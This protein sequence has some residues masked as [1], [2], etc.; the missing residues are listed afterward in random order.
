MQNSFTPSINIVRDFDRLL[1][2]L[3]T[4]NSH[5]I[6]DQIA[7]D[8]Q[9]G[10]RSFNLIGSYGTGKSAFLWAFEKQLNQD[11]TYFGELNGHFNG[12]KK[13]DFVN[14]VGEY[15]SLVRSLA[16]HYGIPRKYATPK[17]V[18]SRLLAHSARLAG[19]KKGLVVA[20]DELGKFLEFAAK[21]NPER[22]LY[23]IQQLSEFCNDSSKNVIL[24]TSLH[25]AFDSYAKVLDQSQRLEWEKVSGRLRELTF[26]EPVEHLLFLAAEY[27]GTQVNIRQRNYPQAAI[28]SYTEHSGAVRFRDYLAGDLARDLNPIEPLA[29][30]ALALALQ[31]YGQNERSLFTFLSSND[32]LGI[33]GYD[34]SANPLFNLSCV[35]DYL[36]SNH[37]SFI[38]T[39]DNPNYVQW[40][41]IQRAIERVEGS[42][43]TDMSGA[44]RLVKS[45]GL[46]NIL[47]VESTKIDD[48]FIVEYGSTALGIADPTAIAKE[49]ESK[50]TLRF[51]Q[52]KS[53]YILFDGT[54]FDFGAAF[55]AASTKVGKL[56]DIVQP[57][58]D[59]FT[60]PAILCKAAHLKFGTPRFFAYQITSEPVATVPTGEVDGIIN[61]LFPIGHTMDQLRAESKKS[62]EAIL[63]CVFREVDTIGE[64]LWEIDKTRFIWSSIGDDLVAK[65]EVAGILGH[66]IGELNRLVMDSMFTERVVWLFRGRE[67]SIHSKSELNKQLSLITQRVY[68]EVPVFHNELIN[69]HRL[70]PG[71]VTAR[72]N[73]IERLLSDWDKDDLAFPKDKFPAE[74]TIY[75]ALLK[76]TGIHKKQQ[77]GWSLRKPSEPS[78]E[79]LW[80]RCEAFLT[81]AKSTQRSV[82]DLFDILLAKPLKL[83]QGL[84]DVWIPI[85]LFI[86][87]EDYA[88]FGEQGY[89][90]TLTSDVIDLI[91]KNPDRFFVKTFDIEGIRLDLLNRYRSFLN[92]EPTQRVSSSSFVDT[93]RPFLSFYRGLPDYAKTTKRLSSHSLALRNVIATAKDPEKT[94]FEEFPAA[95]GYTLDD[96]RTSDKKL[97]RYVEDLQ[98]GI[99]EIRTAF[100]GLIDR[101]EDNL[102]QHLGYSGIRF[103]AY[104]RHLQ[105]RF[106]TLQRHLMLNN[107][108]VLYQRLT[109]E[110]DDRQ[111]W[112]SSVS[113]AVLGKPL[114]LLK[115]EEEAML[116]AKLLGTIAELD[117]LCEITKLEVDSE[118]EEVVRMEITTLSSGTEKHTLRIPKRKTTEAEALSETLRSRLSKDKATN[119]ITLL[120]LLREQN[121]HE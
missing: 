95:L 47:G 114:E 9:S 105:A 25:Q 11:A 54:D 15:D 4:R 120:K 107:Q 58:K 89:I 116:H 118:K 84:A 57:L 34:R 113:H 61:L 67:V 43:E 72:K 63:Y 23:F 80:K 5:H 98:N 94:F 35:Y 29:A 37:Y 38:G 102:L 33:R 41:A 106:A 6:Y 76:N 32:H 16:L 69:R 2:Y 53:R 66:Q 56:T 10:I 108:K 109:S 22:E 81:S 19:K 17:S 26:N 24:I 74:K 101:I 110:I 31:R 85:F 40:A 50:K 13:F 62:G 46:L 83:K 20:I 59:H 78:F 119:I 49:L 30:A 7:A 60:L 104:R 77:T 8:F 82:A 86:R 91:L 88:L 36:V 39:R 117:T 14:I 55:A 42:V 121:S 90:P 111:A 79:G 44:L 71:V 21:N 73:L 28:A 1:T 99:R 18:I 103:P 65:R 68:N 48:K 51:V 115:D 112:L 96:L 87:R 27:L 3:P 97:H 52:F 45:I 92:I 70:P 75:L 100:D 93:I 12:I 64:A